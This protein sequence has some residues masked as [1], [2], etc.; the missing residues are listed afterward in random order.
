MNAVK[1]LQL[2]PKWRELF[3]TNGKLTFPLE[4]SSETSDESEEVKVEILNDFDAVQTFKR[5]HDMMPPIGGYVRIVLDFSGSESFSLNE[6]SYFLLELLWHPR[7]E[8]IDLV[9]EGLQP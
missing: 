8:Q 7:Y 3:E 9:F 1:E 2:S 4:R 5:V 6:L